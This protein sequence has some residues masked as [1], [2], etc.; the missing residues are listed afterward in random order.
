MCFSVK[1][2]VKDV[3]RCMLYNTYRSYQGMMSIVAG[4]LLIVL[5]NACPGLSSGYQMGLIVLGVLLPLSKPLTLLAEA[6]KTVARMDE[7]QKEDIYHLDDH[8]L[9]LVHNKMT[10]RIAW[11]KLHKVLERKDGYYIYATP[12]R[13]MVVPKAELDGETS[14][15]L[16]RFLQEHS[17]NFVCANGN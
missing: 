2:T 16:R 13:F 1:L 9:V 17:G 8:E 14:H 3:Y 4:V 10:T 5:A 7:I 6:R 12:T 11:N 15:Q